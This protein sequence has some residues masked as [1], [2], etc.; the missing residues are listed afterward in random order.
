MSKPQPVISQLDVVEGD[1]P[2]M[3]FGE[4]GVGETAEVNFFCTGELFGGR[5]ADGAGKLNTSYSANTPGFKGDGTRNRRIGKEFRSVAG[6]C[7]SGDDKGVVL[8][9]P[10]I[11]T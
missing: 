6:G 5:L 11:K 9:I 2:E 8:F 4:G 7:F 10:C 1:N 3:K